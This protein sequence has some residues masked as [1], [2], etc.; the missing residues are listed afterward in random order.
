LR[1]SLIPSVLVSYHLVASEELSHH[2]EA[3]RVTIWDPFYCK[4]R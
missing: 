1:S 3:V 4:V 2:L